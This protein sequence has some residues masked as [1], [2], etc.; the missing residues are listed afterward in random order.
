MAVPNFD[1]EDSDMIRAFQIDTYGGIPT[2]RDCTPAKPGPGQVQVNIVACALN[3]AD[4]LMIEGRYQ[5][6]PDLPVTLGMELAGHIGALGDGVAGMSVGDRVAVYSGHGGLAKVGVFAAERCTMIPESVDFDTA[7]A[8]QIAHGTSH[9]AL[10]RRARLQPRETLLVLGAAGGVGLAAVEI[11]KLMGAR[12][13]ACARGQDRLEIARG[14]G[15]DHMIDS[16]AGDLREA[17]LALGGA[18]VIYDPVGGDQFTAAFRACRPEGRILSIGFASGTVPQ[19]PANHLM[20]KNIDV[21]GLNWGGYLQFNPSAMTESLDQ[22]FA[23]AAKG[24]IM[25]QISHRLPLEKAAEALELL[26]SRKVTGKIVVTMPGA[27]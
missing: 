17:V 8:L 2:L 26:R 12:V 6:K 13:I 1:P 23:W 25:P 3:F 5:E 22:V 14:A 4:L 10:A 15:A 7:A 9:L 19:I 27:T 18:D 21:I 11:G 24:Q 16:D 20:V